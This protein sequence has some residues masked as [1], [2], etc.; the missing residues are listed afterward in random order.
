MR[1]FLFLTF[2][3]SLNYSVAQ[4]IIITGKTEQG[5][6]LVGFAEGLESVKLDD[7]E[8]L[9][10]NGIFTFG[11]DRDDK[12]VHYLKLKLKNGK[13]IVK[14]IELHEREYKIQRIN[15]IKKKYVTP[16]KSEMERIKSERKILKS[17]RRKITETDSIYFL[18]GFIRPVK[19][20]RITSV[21]GSQRILNGVPKNPHNGLDIAAPTGT[22]VYA[23]ADGIVVLAG[24]NFYYN[25]NFVLLDHG[26]GLSSIYLHLSK[27]LVK[28]GE[29]VK[30]GQEIGRIGTTGRSTGPHLHWGVNWFGKRID[31]AS[32]LKL[33]LKQIRQGKYKLSSTN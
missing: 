24:A 4:K 19:G 1:I 21:F 2:I 7:K 10:S 12:G 8:L 14:K 25:G 27:I 16:P 18:S 22:P 20:G 9:N 30:K 5:N 33:D 3:L 29:R 28:D 32:L 17:A 13:S 23:T 6:L 11:F 15:K 31:P 26:Q